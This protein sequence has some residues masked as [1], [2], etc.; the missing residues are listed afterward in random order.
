MVGLSIKVT[1]GKEMA[2]G[3]RRLNPRENVRITTKGLGNVAVA[4]QR[5]VASNQIDRGRGA[6]APPLPHR[7]TS[8]TGGAGIVGSIR[9]NRRGLPRYI[10][11]GT[12]KVYGPIHEFGSATHPVRSYLAPGLEAVAPR[13]PGIMV[14]AWRR[15]ARL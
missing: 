6:S 12:D 3:L 10:E 8:R 11:V 13:I 7:L 2:A 15:E 1:G 14:D 9:I 4:I 5:D